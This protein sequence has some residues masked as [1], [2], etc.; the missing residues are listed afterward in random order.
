MHSFI[1]TL[2]GRVFSQQSGLTCHY[3][4]THARL[5]PN[6]SNHSASD[7]L[8]YE[9]VDDILKFDDDTLSQPPETE[10]FPNAEAAI[11]DTV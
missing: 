11:D 5:H 8:D 6:A 9:L 3:R 1:C 10:I 2:R 4:A 7:G